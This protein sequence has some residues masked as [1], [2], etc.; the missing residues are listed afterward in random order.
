MEINIF[1]FEQ[2][3]LKTMLIPFNITNGINI[4]NDFL[5]FCAG[6]TGPKL[7][8]K[9]FVCYTVTVAPV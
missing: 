4:S 9:N 5:K 2:L 3:K 8:P 6:L 1:A 7:D